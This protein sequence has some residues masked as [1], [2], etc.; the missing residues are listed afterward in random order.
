MSDAIRTTC[1]CGC[2]R[3]AHQPALMSVPLG[4]RTPLY[5]IPTLLYGNNVAATHPTAT[6]HRDECGCGCTQYLPDEGP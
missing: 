1:V 5:P 2:P 6:Y 4:R 3:G